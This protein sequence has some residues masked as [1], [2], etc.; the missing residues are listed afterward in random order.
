[1]SEPAPTT[2]SEDGGGDGGDT[3]SVLRENGASAPTAAGR[4]AATGGT[5][6]SLP[7]LQ[8]T[9]IDAGRRAPLEMPPLPFQHPVLESGNQGPLGSV[10]MGEHTC[11]GEDVPF[12]KPSELRRLP[13]II[14]V[15]EFIQTPARRICKIGSEG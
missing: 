9:N 11:A 6:V 13:F 3:I 7:P 15:P 1:M 12:T 8:K 4:Q 14:V 10:G 5:Q 2:P